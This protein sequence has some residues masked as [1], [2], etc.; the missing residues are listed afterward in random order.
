MSLPAASNSVA[1]VCRNEWQVACF[2][3][4]AARTARRNAF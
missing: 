3:I 4:S 2:A 1:N